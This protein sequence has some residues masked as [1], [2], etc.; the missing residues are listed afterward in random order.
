MVCASHSL[1]A[2][3]FDVKR[4]GIDALACAGHKW[5]CA[6]YG[7]GFFYVHKDI[8]AAR[9]PRAIGWMSGQDP[10]AFDP[11]HCEVLPSNRRKRSG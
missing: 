3:P 4:S 5:L 6:G 8:L 11:Q 9:P 2:F 1:G 10:F 7:A